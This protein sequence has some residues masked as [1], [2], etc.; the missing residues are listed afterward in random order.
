MP[1]CRAASGVG[2]N[3]GSGMTITVGRL[4]TFVDSHGATVASVAKVLYSRVMS[5]NDAEWAGMIAEIGRMP[6]VAERLVDEHQPDADGL[7]RA[8]TTPGRGTSRL[9]WPCSLH[10]VGT[11]A[12]AV[13][14]DTEVTC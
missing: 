10:R 13:R 12:L 3:V 11:A 1:N 7:C 14:S 9:P 8:C 5:I 6:G 4:K 2:T